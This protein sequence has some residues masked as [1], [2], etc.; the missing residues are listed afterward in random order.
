MSD[1]TRLR[2]RQSSSPWSAWVL[3]TLDGTVIPYASLTVR[4][5][6]SNDHEPMLDVTLYC[7]RVVADGL[8][9]QVTGLSVLC[10]CDRC[11]RIRTMMK[12]RIP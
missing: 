1:P 4:I 12:E 11:A 8:E 3:E 5:D 7:G 9:A 6:P 2:L 10:D